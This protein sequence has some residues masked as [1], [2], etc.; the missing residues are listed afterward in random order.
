MKRQ[1]PAV[2]TYL[3]ERKNAMPYAMCQRKP[4]LDKPPVPPVL[5]LMMFL[6][7][8]FFLCFCLSLFLLLLIV[9]PLLSPSCLLE[10][11]M[12]LQSMRALFGDFIDIICPPLV[13]MEP[14]SRWSPLIRCSVGVRGGAV[15][16]GE[17]M[18]KKA[19]V[20]LGFQAS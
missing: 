18:T 2:G 6:F 17:R 9:L 12:L 5:H 15:A 14:R 10:S 7:L 3:N 16:L 13:H 11:A 20:G 4:R 1:L 8:R 19:A